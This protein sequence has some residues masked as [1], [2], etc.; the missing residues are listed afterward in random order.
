[1]AVASSI[2][3]ISAI[4]NRA[5]GLIAIWAFTLLGDYLVFG[6]LISIAVRCGCDTRFWLTEVSRIDECLLLS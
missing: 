4:T 2:G 3:R 6:V 5:L 1:M